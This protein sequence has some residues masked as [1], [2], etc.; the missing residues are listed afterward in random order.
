MNA[1]PRWSLKKRPV[2][3]DRDA[4]LG[5]AL[6]LP[7]VT[8]AFLSGLFADVANASG[9][10][11]N[12]QA[13]PCEDP[14]LDGQKSYKK[15]RVS[16]TRSMSRCGKSFKILDEASPAPISIP[17]SP[18][19]SVSSN[20]SLSRQDSLLHQLHC[21]SSASSAKSSQT[22]TPTVFDAT[23]AF[24]HLPPTVSSSSC[25]TLTRNL[26]DLQSSLSETSNKDS[27]GWFVEMDDEEPVKVQSF[28][29]YKAASTSA[30]AFKAPTAPK[31]TNYDAELEWAK[32]A[33]TVDDV[34]GD[35]F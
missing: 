35:F 30:L 12:I 5:H 24:P 23:L 32:A 15:S 16:M 1:R 19:S 13:I 17:V 14:R 22:V 9:E 27:Y 4:A 11:P 2:T 6:G 25:S 28:A 33:D 3:A 7:T 21:V 10:E 26:S 31:A 34:L 29:P 18:P 20:D 8:S